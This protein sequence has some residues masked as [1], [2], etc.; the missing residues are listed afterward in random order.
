M[1]EL[2]G[3]HIAYSDTER[4]ANEANGWVTVS[5]EEFYGQPQKVESAEEVDDPQFSR[6]ELE[7]L[8]FLKFGKKPHHA[9]KDA[10][11]KAKLENGS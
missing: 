3:K 11:I 5:E 9:M 6:K 1:H 7:E 2:H 8:Y 4:L 10:T